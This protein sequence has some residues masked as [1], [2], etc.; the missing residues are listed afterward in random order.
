MV[1]DDDDDDNKG[2]T[3]KEDGIS[4]NEI[5]L[6]L[7]VNDDDK[8]IHQA[9][10]A[11]AI[12][13]SPLKSP[14]KRS[15]RKRGTQSKPFVMFEMHVSS[16]N[17]KEWR[18]IPSWLESGTKDSIFQRLERTSARDLP[19]STQLVEITTVDGNSLMSPSPEAAAGGTGEGGGGGGGG[20]GTGTEEAGGETKDNSSMQYMRRDRFLISQCIGGGRAKE[21]ACEVKNRHLKLVPWGG[22][23]AHLV[24]SGE[25]PEV[26][27]AFCFLP[28]PVQTNLPIHINA[29]FELSSNRRDIWRGKIV[30]FFSLFFLLLTVCDSF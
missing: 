28:L 24:E 2:T 22:V 25:T 13:K 8:E 15:R 10:A 7:A 6:N 21:L 11:A 9:A 17:Q 12:V 1:D 4:E 26:G 18:R 30:F 16:R 5:L 23:A 3:T 14:L 20:T 29:Y 27:R 19:H